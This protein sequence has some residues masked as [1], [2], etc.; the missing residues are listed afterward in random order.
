MESLIPSDDP[1][2]TIPPI[3]SSNTSDSG[4]SAYIAL[5]PTTPSAPG[6]ART[7]RRWRDWIRSDFI[8]L[9]CDITPP[10]SLPLTKLMN[11]HRNQTGSLVTSLWYEK[12]EVEL[13]DP[14]GESRAGERGEAREE[15]RQ[16]DGDRGY[17]EA[18]RDGDA[19][20]GSP[21]SP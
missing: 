19:N 7:L 1:P 11:R 20:D 10:P 12:S 21:S 2:T 3:P 9:P 4:D 6:T 14:D 5:Q 8:V 15:A 16:W 13:K 17:S 18:K